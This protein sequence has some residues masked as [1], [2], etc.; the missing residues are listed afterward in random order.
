VIYCAK[1]DNFF[2]YRYLFFFF[3][4]WFQIQFVH[5]AIVVLA[6]D[7]I[8]WF[9]FYFYFYLLPSPLTPSSPKGRAVGQGTPTAT[10]VSDNNTSVSPRRSERE[11]LSFLTFFRLIPCCTCVHMAERVGAVSQPGWRTSFFFF[12]F[13]QKSRVSEEQYALNGERGM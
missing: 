2:G 11:H 4:P 13:F 1:I 10:T 8:L 9:S 5:S 7:T 3:L 12:F 6:P